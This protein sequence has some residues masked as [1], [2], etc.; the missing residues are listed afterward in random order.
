[1]PYEFLKRTEYYAGKLFSVAGIEYRLPDGRSFTYELVEHSGAITLVPLDVDG[2]IIFVRQFRPGSQTDLLELPAGKLEVD[3][4][5]LSGAA[6]EVREET[7]Q[8]AGNLVRLGNFYMAPGYSNEVMHVF[9]A[10][11]LYTAPLPQDEDEFLDLV[12]IPIPTVLS[13]ARSGRITDAKTLA[14]LFLAQPYLEDMPG[15]R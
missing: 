14:A 7:G 11:E 5:P 9:L 3:E 12:R 13:M 10:T 8:A 15:R 6:R 1:M 4:D 2:C